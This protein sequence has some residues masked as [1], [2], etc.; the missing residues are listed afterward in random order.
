MITRR[1]KILAIA[2]AAL[3]AASP[4]KRAAP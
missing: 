2:L 1:L 4:S 3:F